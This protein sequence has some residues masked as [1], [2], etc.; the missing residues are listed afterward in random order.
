MKDLKN[1]NRLAMK[2][3]IYQV[4]RRKPRRCWRKVP[5]RDSEKERR[6]LPEPQCW[7][8]QWVYSAACCRS[9]LLMDPNIASCGIH[10][11]SVKRS[12]GKRVNVTGTRNAFYEMKQKLDAKQETLYHRSFLMAENLVQKRT[13]FPRLP[14]QKPTVATA[15]IG[16]CKA[17]LRLRIKE[18]P[19]GDLGRNKP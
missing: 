16:A 10:T 7:M 1:D 11:A 2:K 17:E 4:I 18:C 12:F 8:N 5:T 19:P 9:R 3:L 15:F 6:H 14:T 13:R